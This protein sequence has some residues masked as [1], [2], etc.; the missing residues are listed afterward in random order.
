MKLLRVDSS[1]RNSSITRQLTSQFVK[2]WKESNPDGE[3]VERD[4]ATTP[5][6]HITD[7]WTHAVH[8][9]E[10]KRTPQQ[11]QTL[12]LSDQLIGELQSADAVVIGVPMYNFS[13]PWALKAWIDQIVRVGKTF[14]YGANGPIGLLKDKPVIVVTSRG[15]AYPAG[16]PRATY[17]F[18]EPYLRHILG[19]IGLTNVRFVHAENQQPGGALAGPAM[20]AA[21]EQLSQLAAQ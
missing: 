20:A 16:S 3:V 4:L 14:G 18:Q 13:I 6:P 19:F 5:L 15:G 11:R 1:A 7:E 17:D 10:A 21:G 9:E 12:A 8:T 2:G